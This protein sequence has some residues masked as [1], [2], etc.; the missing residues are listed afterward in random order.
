MCQQEVASACVFVPHVCLCVRYVR[1][2][3]GRAVCGRGTGHVCRTPAGCMAERGGREDLA[4]FPVCSANGGHAACS[5]IT[6][7]RRLGFGIP[8][9]SGSRQKKCIGSAYGRGLVALRP[10]SGS[11]WS[12]VVD[13]SACTDALHQVVL[14]LIMVLGAFVG[15]HASLSMA[16]CNLRPELASVLHA[17]CSGSGGNELWRNCEKG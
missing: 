13:S 9:S 7:A 8:W 16:R 6:R 17:T 4:S 10:T 1:Y 14:G 12:L 3:L 5:C 11:A 2:V 15:G